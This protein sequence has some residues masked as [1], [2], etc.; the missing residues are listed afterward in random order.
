MGEMVDDQTANQTAKHLKKSK[1]KKNHQ[2]WNSRIGVLVVLM[3]LLYHPV[4]LF[5]RYNQIMW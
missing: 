5:F 1:K 4:K 2:F 3:L